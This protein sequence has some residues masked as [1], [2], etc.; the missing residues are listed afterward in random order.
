L[1]EQPRRAE[2]AGGVGGLAERLVRVQR[3]ARLGL[4]VA[5]REQQPAAV[6]GIAG[7]MLERP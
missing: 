4:G 3:V 2:R 1:G 5:A 6:L 7:R